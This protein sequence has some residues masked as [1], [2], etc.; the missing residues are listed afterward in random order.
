MD[1]IE[2]SPQDLDTPV[3]AIEVAGALLRATVALEKAAEEAAERDINRVL[4][5]KHHPGNVELAKLTDRLLTRGDG[6]S[7]GVDAIP[8]AERDARATGVCETWERLKA[9]GPEDGPL[10]TWSYTRHLA[11]TARDMVRA[12]RERRAAQLRSIA[13]FVGRPDLPPLAPDAR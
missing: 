9:D 7:G 5:M 3:P 11:L 8:V 2:L 10:G 4:R 13:P 6:L 1:A 12:L